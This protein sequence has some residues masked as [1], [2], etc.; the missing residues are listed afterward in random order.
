VRPEYSHSSESSGIPSLDCSS[1][2]STFAPVSWRALADLFLG[3]S[4][5]SL[6]MSGMSSPDLH[7]INLLTYWQ[8]LCTSCLYDTSTRC[9]ALRR[10]LADGFLEHSKQLSHL[11]T[12]SSN[13]SG[14]PFLDCSSLKSTFAPA[15]QTALA[16]LFL[17]HSNGFR[18]CYPASA[19]LATHVDLLLY[20][21]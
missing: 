3:C 10:A 16:D 11:C 19:P 15:L 12:S 9:P 13:S 2:K 14:I 20:M 17:E 7:W 5:A 4:K 6:H 18:C 1:L 8:D 21:L